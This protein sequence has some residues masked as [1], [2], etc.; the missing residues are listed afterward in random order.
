MP[1]QQRLGRIALEAHDGQ[2]QVFGGDVFIVEVGRL[3]KSLLEDFAGGWG[4]FSLQGAAGPKR[5]QAVDLVSS[6]R[7]H[8]WAVDT[9]LA[10]HRHYHAFAVC[11]EDREQMDGR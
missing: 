11:Q 4:G 7:Q 9:K 3:L 10:Q 2:E 8:C 1:R 6:L 5:W